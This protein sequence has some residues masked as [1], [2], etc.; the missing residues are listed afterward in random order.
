MNEGVV[1]VYVQDV[2]GGSVA[3]VYLLGA[4]N[5]P[6]DVVLCQKKLLMCGTCVPLPL[7]NVKFLCN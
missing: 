2:L 4:A 7:Y 1:V 6:K 5:N 3:P